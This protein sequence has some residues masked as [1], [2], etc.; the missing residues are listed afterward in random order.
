VANFSTELQKPLPVKSTSSKKW[1][2]LLLW[3]LP[4]KE[5]HRIISSSVWKSLS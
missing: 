1:S 5:N 4:L 3:S 2:A